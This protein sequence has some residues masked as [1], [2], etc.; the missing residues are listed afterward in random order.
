MENY[1]TQTGVSLEKA[2]T[3]QMNGA[4]EAVKKQA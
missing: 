2:T 1:L 3:D 4:W